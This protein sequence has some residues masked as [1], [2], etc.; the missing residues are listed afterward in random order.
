MVL[1]SRHLCDGVGHGAS[2]LRRRW[3]LGSRRTAATGGRDCSDAASQGYVWQPGYWRWTGV[4]YIWVSG[5]Y[6]PLPQPGLTWIPGRWVPHAGRW[7]WVNGY[8]RP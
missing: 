1:D 7:M 6:A 8:W 3:R 4:R 2:R 5:S